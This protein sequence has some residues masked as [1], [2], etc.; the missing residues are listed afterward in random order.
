VVYGDLWQRYQISPSNRKWM[1]AA[2]RFALAVLRRCDPALRRPLRFPNAHFVS[3][4]LRE[5]ALEINDAIHNSSVIY[6]GVDLDRFRFQQQCQDPYRLL[7]VGQV[8][9]HK[10][11]HTVISAAE[12]LIKGGL[13]NVRLTVVGGSTDSR[14]ASTLHEMVKAAGIEKHVEFCG[15]VPRESLPDVY[16][17]HGV[18]VFASEFDEPFSITLLEAMACG[19]PVV[20]TGRGGTPEAIEHLCN[21]LIFEASNPRDCAAQVR[22]LLDDG[23][24]RERLRSNARRIVEERFDLE[25]MVNQIESVLM[26]AVSQRSRVGLFSKEYREKSNADRRGI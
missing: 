7:Y 11:V 22:R 15:G 3:R 19:I 16:R 8:M 4:S 10:G 14:Y 13:N 9:P 2:K 21:G 24:L 1:R 20:A 18:L 17:S 23:E 12:M 26:S 25:Q 6:W 5:A